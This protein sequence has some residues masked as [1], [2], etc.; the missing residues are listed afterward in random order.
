MTI[1]RINE[2]SSVHVNAM[3]FLKDTEQMI[4]ECIYVCIAGNDIGSQNS[5]VAAV[6][7]ASVIFHA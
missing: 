6:F 4:L 5:C 2:H 1:N 3:D 7:Q